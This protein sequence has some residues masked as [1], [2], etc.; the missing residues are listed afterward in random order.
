MLA[1]IIFNGCDLMRIDLD[2]VMILVPQMLNA[3]ELILT[4]L[5]PRFKYVKPEYNE[6][7][8]CRT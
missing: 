8:Y 6:G 1:N 5:S 3:L 4:D 2:G 7:D